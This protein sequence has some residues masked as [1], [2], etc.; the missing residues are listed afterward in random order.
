[1]RIREVDQNVRLGVFWD[2]YPD[3]GHG[4][5][6]GRTHRE[7][8]APRVAVVS[9]HDHLLFQIEGAGDVMPVQSELTSRVV[10]KPEIPSVLREGR[11]DTG[12][13]GETLVAVEG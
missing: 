7:A 1:M 11:S 6:D 8:T 13:H 2:L 5:N 4:L 12:P 3:T 10:P 9:A